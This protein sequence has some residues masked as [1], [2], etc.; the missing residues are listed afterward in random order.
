MLMVIKLAIFQPLIP[1]Y[2]TPVFNQLAA[3]GEVDV[4]V[5]AG[6]DIGSLKSDDVEQ[7]FQVVNRPLTYVNFFGHRFCLQKG[8]FSAINNR[9]YDLVVL[10]W[11]LHYLLLP[12]VIAYS[13]LRC[14]PVVLWGHGYSKNPSYLSDM[15]RNFYG[16]CADAVLVYSNTIAL[17]LKK[18][19]GFNENKVFVAQN[20]ISTKAQ[21]LATQYWSA[22]PV[23]LEAFKKKYQL[24]CGDNLI[25]VSRLEPDNRVEM[26]IDGLE[27]FH[28]YSPD[29][30]LIVVGD[31]S[32][33]QYLTEYV[34]DRGLQDLVIFT[35]AIYDEMDLAPWMLSAMLFCYPRN[36]G[37]SLMHAFSYALPVVT[38]DNIMSHNPEIEA[39]MPGEN[40]LLFK[41]GDV[42][43]MVAQW[44]RLSQNNELRARMAEN[45]LNQINKKYNITN[46]IQGFIDLKCLVK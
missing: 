2:R 8:M 37:L 40:G 9:H 19:Y 29:A 5:Y 38:G 35:G 17:K 31:G 23:R 28:K 34:A 45:A 41:D 25:Y 42:D 13:K 20:A 26:L 30:K 16:K 10:S 6:G 12:F 39:I 33:R 27:K 4:T 11:D 24:T 7:H 1:K 43:D 46:M 18:N 22:N 44:V 15:L 3:S 14:K 36:I 21:N 32:Y